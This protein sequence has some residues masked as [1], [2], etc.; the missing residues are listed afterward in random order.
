VYIPGPQEKDPTKIPTAIRQLATG[1]SN[2]TGTVTLVP[3]ATT[4]LVIAHNCM[5]D[6]IPFL[7]PMS[8]SAQASAAWISAVG[9]GHFTITHASNAAVD[10]IMGWVCL[11]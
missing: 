9:Q 2:A 11:G 8:A 5:A 3:S 1:R 4:T 7:S 6:S 10:Q